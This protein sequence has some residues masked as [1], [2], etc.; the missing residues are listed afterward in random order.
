[1]DHQAGVTTRLQTVAYLCYSVTTTNKRQADEKHEMW[2]NTNSPM[3]GTPSKLRECYQWI[4]G[5]QSSR[6]PKWKIAS[7]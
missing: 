1:M 2:L 7:L 6:I 3:A 4:T 5:I